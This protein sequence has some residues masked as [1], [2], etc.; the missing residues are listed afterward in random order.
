MTIT[1]L[2]GICSPPSC[3]I[4]MVVSVHTTYHI[5]EEF[6]LT[7]MYLMVLVLM[8]MWCCKCGWQWWRDLG[9]KL[10]QISVEA[11]WGAQGMDYEMKLVMAA[12]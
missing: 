8:E 2:L 9:E 6:L 11:R 12:V 10:L 1:Y 7:G 4:P 5:L 3:N